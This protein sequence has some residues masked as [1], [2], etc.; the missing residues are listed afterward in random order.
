MRVQ[1]LVGSKRGAPV[2][3]FL[4]EPARL[5]RGDSWLESLRG[6]LSVTIVVRPEGLGGQGQG[7]CGSLHRLMASQ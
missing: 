4:L 6:H 5:Q 1:V 7:T 2:L 3:R